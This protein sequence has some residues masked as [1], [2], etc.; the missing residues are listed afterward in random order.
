MFCARLIMTMK[1]K[2]FVSQGELPA[3]VGR[4]WK[5]LNRG[6]S[7]RLAKRFPGTEFSHFTKRK[8]KTKQH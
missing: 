2:T 1:T 8:T 5:A 4:G 7:Q 6:L 3:D